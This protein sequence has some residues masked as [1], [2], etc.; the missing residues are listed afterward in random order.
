MLQS[1]LIEGLI[2]GLMVLGVFV[3]FRVLNF[4]DMTVDGS[5]PMGGAIMATLLVRG[6]PPAAALLLAFCG[7]CAAGFV[8]ALIHNKFRLPDLLAGILTMTMLYSVNLRIMSGRANLSLLRVPTLFTGFI[9]RLEGFASAETAILI[10]LLA[11]ILF[12][13]I[14]L[15]VFFHT[16]FGLTMG[17]LG[18]NEQMIVSQGMNPAVIKTAGICLGNGLAAA[19][20]AFSAMFQGFA[21]VGSGSGI[22]VS[23]LASLMLGE[24]LIKSNKIALLTLRALFGSIIYRGLMYFARSYGYVIGMNVND[25]KLITGL[26]II[27]CLIV[28]KNDAVNRVRKIIFKNKNLQEQNSRIEKNRSNV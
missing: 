14:L 6:A 11:I 10:L 26:L 9:T 23:G 3:T 22:I 15:D 18:S 12:V 5:F 16:D 24:F 20:G 17:A 25:L 2:Y 8:T 19:S 4:A 28:S 1:I 7:G 13:K 27:L 21:D